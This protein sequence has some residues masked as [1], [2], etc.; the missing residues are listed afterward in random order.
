MNQNEWNQDA[1]ARYAALTQQVALVDVGPRTEVAIRGRDRLRVM[2]NNCTADLRRLRPGQGA[3]AFVLNIKGMTVGHVGLFLAEDQLELSTVENQ[4]AELVSH[5]Q[6]YIVSEDVQFVD[7]SQ[8][9]ASLLLAGPDAERALE[10]LGVQSPPAERMGHGLG[11]LN[12]IAVTIRRTELLGVDGFHL[13]LP[14]EA[15]EKVLGQ[16]LA[17]SIPLCSKEILDAVR[18]ENRIP[19]Y[20]CDIDAKNLPQEVGRDQAAISFTKGCYLGQETVARL[21]ALG[22]VNRHW[23]ALVFDGSL[24]PP[25]GFVIEREGK[26]VARIT[27]AT[28]SPKFG[29]PLA[30]GYVRDGVHHVGQSFASHL[31]AAF[32]VA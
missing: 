16:I 25:R 26:P 12:A 5:L 22:H 18:I 27:S 6:Q 17:Q 24:V 19:Q 2:N 29:R 4:A 10:T 23:V 9:V 8:D 13:V 7:R 14:V 31:G 20:G 3:E 15:K 30:L 32:V 11:V 28:W 21:D 1:L